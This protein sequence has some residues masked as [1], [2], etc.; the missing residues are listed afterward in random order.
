MNYQFLNKI[1]TFIK[2]GIRFK[3]SKGQYYMP[4]QFERLA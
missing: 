2:N 4:T 3:D 1:Q